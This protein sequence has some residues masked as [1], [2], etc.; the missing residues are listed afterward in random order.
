MI[1]LAGYELGTLIHESANTL[2]YRGRRKSD[3]LAVVLKILKRD[4]PTPTELT[5]YQHEY[6][7]L[8]KLNLNGVIK[9]Y[10]LQES[11]NTLVIILED[12]SGESLE[13]LMVSRRVTLPE[14]L[15]LAIKITNS[16]GFVHAANII[17]KDINPSNIV[18]NSG[19]GQVKL[20]DFGISMVLSREN[21]AI[22]NPNVLEGTL[23]YMSP[24]QT[25][26]MNRLL[27][28]R[29]DFYS[30]GATFYKLLTHQL[31]F[32]VTD[33]MELVHCH[34]AIEP[35]PPAQVNNE[36]PK[37]VSNMVMK[38]LAKTAEERY[39]SAW[40]IKADLEKCLNQLQGAGTIDEFPLALHDFSDKFQIPQKL[41]GREQEIETL[42]AA[43]ERVGVY[44][45]AAEHRRSEL[46]LIS[47]Y[48]GI[49]KTSLVQVLYRPITRQRG[50]FIA[51][52]FDQFQRN[53]PYSAVIKAFQELVR[54]L[55]TESES[56]L[57]EWR[58]KLAAAL[59]PNGQILIDVIPEVEWIMGKQPAAPGLP[60][61]ESQNRL[62]LVFQNFIQVFTKPEHP[63]VIFL[64]D[65]QW[66][67][68]ASLNLMKLLMTASDSQCLFLIGAYR[69]NEVN[70]NHPL[71][72]T[73][74]DI[75]KSEVIVNHI[76]LSTL[77][78]LDIN[79]LI[80]DTLNCTLAKAQ[81]L[82][83]LVL[84][85][86][87]GNPFFINEF[88]KSLYLEKLLEFNPPQSATSRFTT[89]SHSISLSNGRTEGNQE[90]WWWDIEKIK[91][92]S[93][94]DNVIEL[95]AHK[96]QKLQ[97]ETQQVLQLAAAIGNSFDLL[98]LAAVTQRSPSETADLLREGI[99][100]GLVSAR[101]GYNAIRER[102][103]Q[104]SNVKLQHEASH[105]SSSPIAI[106]Y[107]FAHDRIQQ[108]AYSLI[109][110][111]DK[112]AIHR[113]I[114]Q[115]L[116][117]HTPLE[118]R[119]QKIFSL[120][121]QLNF[122][123]KLIT[124][125]NERD[126]LAQLNLMAGRKAKASA[127]Y[128][129]AF[130]YLLVGIK[131]LILPQSPLAKEKR[132]RESSWLHQYDLTLALYVEAAEAAYLSGDFEQMERFAQQVVQNARS[133]LDQVKVYKVKIEAYTGQNK[134][135]EAVTTG[136]EVLARLGVKFP[137]KPNKLQIYLGWLRTKLALAGKPINAL[138]NLPLMTDPNKVAAMQILGSIATTTYL[139]APSLYPFVVFKQINLS[140]NYGNAIESAC[141]YAAYGLFLCGIVGDIESGY[142]FGKL[143][144]RLLEQFDTPDLKAMTINVVYNFIMHWKESI[145]VTLNP[146]REAYRIGLETGDLEFAAY[147]AHVR[148]VKL[149]LI[150]Q[151]LTSLE[152]E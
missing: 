29:T 74:N 79:Q 130:N 7:I 111:A 104:T 141:G 72:L 56:Q 25:G 35:V 97:S 62:M 90:G 37:A 133:L 30:L 60:P 59:E 132:E 100:E 1:P 136:V 15:S 99:I 117:Q 55:L 23:P 66:A 116:L 57:N 47:G 143:A 134:L 75:Q 49:G 26:R 138:I 85:K 152:Q 33:A 5:Q 121:N 107:K 91:A 36:I 53:I 24:E 112:P 127:A 48:A 89:S 146:L 8:R 58:E 32:E 148:S 52:K 119:E 63:L 9:A 71:M 87:N 96:I 27:D 105:S 13:N 2:V 151:E 81:P 65:L 120:V 102:S 115:L 88:L 64:D 44:G 86:T 137:K 144:L 3:N 131:L 124:S 140:V 11:Q 82:A 114:G 19:T 129:P 41:Y 6:E 16:L 128:E 145:R 76:S 67:D 84:E 106:E 98:N 113:Q 45:C 31:P 80:S 103:L 40:G 125:Q 83:E 14:F 10:G 38:L 150:G 122:G 149:Y 92:R 73:L 51:G 126:E 4:Y 21:P 101:D 50:Y 28:Y 69:D 139:A 68:V 18:Y 70:A 142:Q 22:K 12:F 147:S 17:H 108:A 77:N 39:Q 109:P 61:A 20:I 135:L 78:L 118:Q 123:I 46:V 94:T 54:Q 93:I 95:L 34:I 43:F 110:E 42:M